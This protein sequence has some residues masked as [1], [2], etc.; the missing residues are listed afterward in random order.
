MTTKPADLRSSDP[1]PAASIR[2]P[3]CKSGEVRRSRWRHDDGLL[4]KF[5]YA[6]YRCRDCRTR[7][8]RFNGGAFAVFASVVLIL[9]AVLA[10][11]LI[12]I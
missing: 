4:R 12:H 8:S 7:F 5:L 11:S 3:A 10:L 6:R 2:C 9:G 1:A